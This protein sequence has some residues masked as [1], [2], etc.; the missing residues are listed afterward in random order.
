MA[1][2]LA[3]T[4]LVLAAACGGERELVTVSL[5]RLVADQGSYEGRRVETR[6]RVEA[7]GEEAAARH[8]VV[9]DARANRVQLL[10]E[11]AAAEYLGREV[12][13]VGEFGFDERRGRFVRVDRIRAAG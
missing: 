11:D 13:V 7:F 3:A 12:I 1:A 6:G 8:Y 4:A 5:S 2:L 10:P 9:E